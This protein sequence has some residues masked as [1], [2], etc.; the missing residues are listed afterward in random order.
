MNAWAA[1]YRF[2][3]AGGGREAPFDFILYPL[4]NVRVA[5]GEDIDRRVIVFRP[6][7]RCNMAFRDDDDSRQPVRVELVKD[8]FDDARSSLFGR[9]DQ[10]A[11]KPLLVEKKRL[12]AMLELQ[13]DMG[14]KR[15][16]GRLGEGGGVVAL[17]SKHGCLL[18]DV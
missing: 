5:A 13:Q 1:H 14:A 9:L 2:G 4:G 18:G 8:G 3:G 16:Y 10:G 6:R 11:L 15:L 17:V 7:V 12:G